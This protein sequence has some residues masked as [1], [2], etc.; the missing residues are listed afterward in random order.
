MSRCYT[1]AEVAGRIGAQLQGEGSATL[2]GIA[3]LAHATPQQLTFLSNRRYR[4]QLA[5]T[6]AA[7]V[8]L[9]AS[10]A[11]SAPVPALI[12]DHPY[13]AFARAS[14]LFADR[15]LPP[16]GIDPSAHIAPT[17]Q[18]GQAVQIGPQV[19]I[20]QG[21]VIGDRVAIGAGSFIGADSVIGDES[22][23]LPRVTIYHRCRIGRQALIH[24]GVVIGSDGFGFAE[25]AGEWFKIE[26][27]GGVTIGDRVEIGANTTIDRGALDDTVIGH[28]VKLDNLIQ[29]AHNVQIG[30]HTA[31]A[32]CVG[33]AGSAE[34]GRHCQIAGGVGILGHLT[35][36]DRVTITAMSLVTGS[37]DQPGVYSAGTP[38]EPHRQ[39]QKSFVRL[40]QLDQMARRLRYVEQQLAAPTLQPEGDSH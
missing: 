16:C 23:L 10:D 8:I 19:V 34:I 3:T 21:A 1:V 31:I 32:A 35:I 37:I 7:A 40:K 30:D 4:P 26:Q 24:A 33:I 11:A 28:G 2:T 25:A 27:L 20:E 15:P 17:A 22:V 39:W 5:T 12:C 18:I 29:I 6:Q 38:L 14:A 9:A 36:T 13:L